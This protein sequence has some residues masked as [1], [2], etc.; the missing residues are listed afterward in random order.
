[1]EHGAAVK[2]QI[3][4]LRQI[5]L[6]RHDVQTHGGRDALE[7]AG[8]VA[9]AEF[10]RRLSE[11]L[12]LFQTR[13]RL[14]AVGIVMRTANQRTGRKQCRA[15]QENGRAGFMRGEAVLRFIEECL[16][17]RCGSTLRAEQMS[18]R[19]PAGNCQRTDPEQHQQKHCRH[20]GM[21]AEIQAAFQ[22]RERHQKTDPEA[23]AAGLR[24][25]HQHIG[26]F[27]Q[28]DHC[29]NDQHKDEL[30]TLRFCP[31]SGQPCRICGE[32]C[33]R[34]DHP[35]HRVIHGA[36]ADDRLLAVFQ[37]QNRDR[38]ECC[39]NAAEADARGNH[40][41]QPHEACQNDDEQ[42]QRQNLNLEMEKS[43]HTAEC[44]DAAA[45]RNQQPHKPFRELLS[46]ADG[47]RNAVVQQQLILRAGYVIILHN[48]APPSNSSSVSK[49]GRSSS[50]GFSIV[51][52]TGS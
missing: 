34:K 11:L 46:A 48:A 36:C 3:A 7:Q 52:C 24:M 16:L 37:Q 27:Q 25:R 6:V 44:A 4:V 50:R 20:A 22:E 9:H 8:D 23:A 38:G 12:P 31:L 42:D 39:Q 18:A 13:L 15:A 10:P 40:A 19:L 28:R 33:L 5:D 30:R 32:R 21:N 1:M 41:D 51:G 26:I 2:M 14:G 49:S 43:L 45:K 17:E 47:H 29:R 35:A